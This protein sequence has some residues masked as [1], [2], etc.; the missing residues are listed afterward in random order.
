LSSAAF[1]KEARLAAT[2]RDGNCGAEKFLRVCAAVAQTGGREGLENLF[3]GLVE[4]QPCV[5]KPVGRSLDSSVKLGPT[6]PSR[7]FVFR[8]LR[9]EER[10]Q[11]LA[12][13]E[14]AKRLT[15]RGEKEKANLEMYT[16]EIERGFVLEIGGE[17]VRGFPVPATGSGPVLWAPQGNCETVDHIHM[18][19]TVVTFVQFTTSGA[20]SRYPSHPVD[21]GVL[22]AL[23]DRVPWAG[24]CELVRVRFMLPKTG[25]MLAP[26]RFDLKDTRPSWPAKLR[27]WH[28]DKYSLDGCFDLSELANPEGAELLLPTDVEPFAAPPDIYD[29]RAVLPFT[30]AGF[31]GVARVAGLPGFVPAVVQLLFHVAA[32]RNRVLLPAVRSA[33]EP[34]PVVVQALRE[35]FMVLERKA[36]GAGCGSIALSAALTHA[37]REVLE[38]VRWVLARLPV[39]FGMFRWLRCDET[40][41]LVGWDKVLLGNNRLLGSFQSI[42]AGSPLSGTPTIP[43]IPS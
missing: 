17:R 26:M 11:V 36:Q 2:A 19:E 34:W 29:R 15:R 31:I 16:L 30:E 24:S 23:I 22:R 9:V 37:P 13:I 3:T 43:I 39:A 10:V 27:C 1:A 32:F 40:G 8:R 33:D 18:T 38:F 28:G 5:I 25:G 35:A 6:G 21:V 4:W 7:R 41:T 20:E 12:E 14:Q 42:L